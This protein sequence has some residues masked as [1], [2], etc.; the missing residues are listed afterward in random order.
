MSEV[1]VQ[2]SSYHHE[3]TLMAEAKIDTIDLLKMDIEGAELE[4]FEN[5]D[6]MA[7]VQVIVIELHDHIK[8][9]CRA[10][11]SSAAQ[12]LPAVGTRRDGHFLARA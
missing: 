4:A 5:C 8:P 3:N 12:G 11:V 7:G 6:W 9:G 2:T 1:G 10:A